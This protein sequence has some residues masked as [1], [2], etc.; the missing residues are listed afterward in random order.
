[1]PGARRV[2]VRLGARYR[3]SAMPGLVSRKVVQDQGVDL[4]GQ[5]AVD[6]VAGGFDDG[7]AG[8]VE[9]GVEDDGHAGEAIEGGDEGVE[10]GDG[11]RG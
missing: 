7:P 1:M 3:G 6:R 4:G 8:D 5:E 9:G 2:W 11:R 10:A